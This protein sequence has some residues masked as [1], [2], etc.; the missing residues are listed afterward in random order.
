LTLADGRGLLVAPEDPRALA[1]GIAG[2]LRGDERTD[3]DGGRA[4]AA[5]FEAGHVAAQY[6]AVYRS[7]IDGHRVG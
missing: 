5:R 2:I 3:L 7:V 6:A 1:A 4:Y